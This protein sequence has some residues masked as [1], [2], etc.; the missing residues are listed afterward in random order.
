MLRCDEKY[1]Q[2]NLWKFYKKE[3]IFMEILV[4]LLLKFE[5][6]SSKILSRFQLNFYGILDKS[7]MKFIDYLK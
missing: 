5:Q 6:F 1:V 4:I 2:R 7:P 3:K